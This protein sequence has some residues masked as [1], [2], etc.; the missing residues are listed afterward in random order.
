VRKEQAM[1]TVTSLALPAW[2]ADT[3]RGGRESDLTAGPRADRRHGNARAGEH[4]S[5]AREVPGQR[6]QNRDPDRP[7]CNPGEPGSSATL[8]YRRAERMS[9]FLTTQQ[10]DTVELRIKARDSANLAATELVAG[11]TVI[12]ELEVRTRSTTKISV[13]VNGELNADELAA[14][15]GVIEQVGALAQDFFDGGLP[16]AFAAAEALTMDA[17]QLANVGLRLSVRE[18]LT[19]TQRGAW[20]N[21]APLPVPVTPSLPAATDATATPATDL[22]V[23]AATSAV[24]DPTVTPAPTPPTVPVAGTADSPAREARALVRS[25]LTELMS[26]LAA[27]APAMDGAN[28]APVE[29][30]LK[31]RVFQSLVASISARTPATPLPVLVPDTLE[32]LAAQQ[33]APLSA[34]A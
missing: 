3:W 21:V 23:A 29:R 12:A 13:V 4:L 7:S 24:A 25:F 10:G 30:A 22:P 1:A 34:V 9:L 19:Y 27:P 8:S 33:E 20:Q 5:L 31:L 14:I 18:Q 15:R 32:A 11:E 28:G 2:A 26:R 6:C 17:T 16:D